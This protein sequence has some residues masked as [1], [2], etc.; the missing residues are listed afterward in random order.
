MRTSSNAQALLRNWQSTDCWRRSRN[1]TFQELR[2]SAPFATTPFNST[3]GEIQL[4]FVIC[5]GLVPMAPGGEFVEH[6]EGIALRCRTSLRWI[7]AT[8]AL[9][10]VAACGGGHGGGGGGGISPPTALSYPSPPTYTVG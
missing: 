1:E 8:L 7:A 10:G 5:F 4:S 9:I 6:L 2:P 3:G